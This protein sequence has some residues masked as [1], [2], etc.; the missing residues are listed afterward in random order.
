VACYYWNN[1]DGR[2][3]RIKEAQNLFICNTF[4]CAVQDNRV[5]TYVDNLACVFS[6]ENMS[7]KD[8]VLVG[9]R[10]I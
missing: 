1:T 4:N 3:I 9:S 10:R 7:S 8:P 5:D 2:I 6:Y